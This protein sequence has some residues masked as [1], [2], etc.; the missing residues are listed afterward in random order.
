VFSVLA[1]LKKNDLESHGGVN[2]R[3]SDVEACIK[4]AKIGKI[5]FLP[6]EFD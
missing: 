4:V 3:K 6:I 5:Y 2:A 1:E